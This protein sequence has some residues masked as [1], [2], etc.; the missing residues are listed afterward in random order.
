MELVK[1]EKF[2]MVGRPGTL[3][4]YVMKEQSGYQ[5]L[6]LKFTDRVMDVG[7]NIGA[8]ARWAEP[9]CKE[10]ISYE[11][12]NANFQIL[13]ENIKGRQSLMAYQAALVGDDRKTVD[14]YLNN[15]G[16]HSTVERRGRT[17][18][19]VPALN[20]WSELDQHKPNVVKMDIEGGEYDILLGR[21][22]PAYVEKLAIEIHLNDKKWRGLLSVD[23]H[24]K[25]CETFRVV[26]EPRFTPKGWATTAFYRR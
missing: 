10:V 6:G 26:K 3:D 11:P 8:F 24:K 17:K 7:G 9:Q 25:L 12:D 23:L 13:C 21:E 22:L 5:P 16:M 18:V 2:D 4:E 15:K 14:F 1:Y 20:F 19:T